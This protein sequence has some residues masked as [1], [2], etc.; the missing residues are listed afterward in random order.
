MDFIACKRR[1]LVKQV[2]IDH[3]LIESLLKTSSKKLQTQ[4]LLKLNEDT[5]S[6]KITLIYDAMRELLEALAISNGYKIYNHECYTSFLKE[7][8]KES[9]LGDK[10]DSFRR[11]RNDINYYG[12]DISAEDSK[13]IINDMI[14]FVE[15]LKIKFF[16][17][18]FEK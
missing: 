10:F 8:M 12:K 3:N 15:K 9:S 13:H 14:A 7:V 11:I 2:R 4:K 6:S 18:S 1:N 17:Y 16:K 5:A